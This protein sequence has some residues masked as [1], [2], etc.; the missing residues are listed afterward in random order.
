[1]KIQITTAALVLA[2]L[3][4]AAQ[5][6]RTGVSN[7]DNTAISSNDDVQTTQP[8]ADTGRRPLTEAKPSAAVPATPT[9]EVY[10]AY[11]PYNPAGGASAQSASATAAAP[12]D[13]DAEI[14]TSVPE[15]EN[16][17]RE[18]TLLHVRIRED[19]STAT[20]VPGTKFSAEVME[21]IDREGRVIIPI[22]SILNGQVT[23]VH[24]GHRISGAAALHL[25]PRSVTLPDGTE[26]VLHAQLVDTSISQFNVDGEG[27][28][29]RR[30][31]PKETLAVVGLA[32]GGGAAAGAMIGGGVGALVGGGIGAGVSTY[33]WLKSD[34]QATLNKDVRLVFSLTAPMELVP[35]KAGTNNSVSMNG[36]AG[37]ALKAAPTE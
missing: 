3:P 26:Y 14:V 7:P 18:G 23:E 34:R 20:T 25:E 24:T 6:A 12:F 2:T 22:G 16:E 31:H 36:G 13:P 32:T 15:G 10:G 30:D 21:P 29:K 17:L 1:M 9:T 19:L 37:P 27:T 5:T 8:T 28:L 4:A 33:M 11:V 35:L